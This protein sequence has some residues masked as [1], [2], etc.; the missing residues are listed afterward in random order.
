MLRS[1]ERRAA[2]F[3]SGCES[4]TSGAKDALVDRI[5]D[6]RYTKNTHEIATLFKIDH[7]AVCEI[8]VV[9]EKRIRTEHN[10]ALA[11]IKRKGTALVKSAIKKRAENYAKLRADIDR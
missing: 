2:S 3:W 8:I 9:E 6:M 11:S 5:M 7:D 10:K 4:E 1:E